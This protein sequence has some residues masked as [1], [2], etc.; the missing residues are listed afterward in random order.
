[1]PVFIAWMMIAPM[2]DMAIEKRPPSSDVPPMT[3]ARMASS[4]SHRPALLAS[5][6]RMSPAMMMPDIPAQSPE[7][8]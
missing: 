7:K 2:T 4:S 6:P 5:A 3:T 8:V 1:M